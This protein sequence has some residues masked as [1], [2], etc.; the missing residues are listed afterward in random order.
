VVVLSPPKKER[1]KERKR[2]A[3]LLLKSSLYSKASIIRHLSK[4]DERTKMST[5]AQKAAKVPSSS[6]S[7][8]S[9]G[10]RSAPAHVLFASLHA[11]SAWLSV[12]SLALVKGDFGDDIII[13]HN[14]EGPR[15]ALALLHRSA[16]AIHLLRSAMRT[17]RELRNDD[18]SF[19][20]RRRRQ[21]QQRRRRRRRISSSKKKRKSTVKILDWVFLRNTQTN[22]HDAKSTLERGERHCIA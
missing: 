18:E 7:S 12:K 6:L 19:F 22:A 4:P 2:S 11:L 14:G 3:L 15:S 8:S 21:K 16:C 17:Y 5:D 1:K 9:S 13:T 10:G 20:G